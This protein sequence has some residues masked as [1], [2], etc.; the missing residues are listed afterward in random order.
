MTR[1]PTIETLRAAWRV[2][3]DRWR[4]TDV[5]WSDVV[6][7]EFEKKFWHELEEIVLRG[8]EEIELLS[9]LIEAAR[10]DVGE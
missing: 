3:Q 9:D 8:L 1:D 7:N 2:L 4:A 10:T 6:R 5:Q